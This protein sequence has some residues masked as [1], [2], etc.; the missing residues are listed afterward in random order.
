[1]GTSKKIK[2][3]SVDSQR[4]VNPSQ[5]KNVVACQELLN[6]FCQEIWSAEHIAIIFAGYLLQIS[7]KSNLY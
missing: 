4:G 5:E 1:M 3:Y 6:Q 7:C 2:K